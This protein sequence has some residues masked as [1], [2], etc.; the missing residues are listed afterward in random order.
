MKKVMFYCQHLAGMGHLVRSTEIIRSLLQEFQVYFINGGQDV[1]GFELPPNVEVITLPALRMEGPELKAVDATVSLE[2]VQESRKNL[3]LQMFEQIQPDCF[4]TESFPFSKHA[5]RFELIPLLKHIQASGRQTRVVCCL[6]DIIMTQV[7]TDSARAKKQE[8]TCNWVSQYYD[9]VLFHSDPQLQRLEECFS[10]VEDLDCEIYYTGFVA[11]SPPTH[12]A[13]DTADLAALNQSEPMILGSVGGGRHGYELLN[14]IAEASPILEKALPHKIYLFTGPFMAEA[15]V[16]K[17]QAA[18]DQ[19]KN[20]TIRR[21]TPHLIDYMNKADLSISMAG[22]NTTMN[23]LRTGVRSLVFPSPSEDQSG[24]QSLRSQKLEKL[25]VLQMLQ[26]DDL[27]GDRLAQKMITYLNQKPVSHR[28]TH[29]F[30]LQ[31]APKSASRLKEL[32]NEDSWFSDF[33]AIPD[34]QAPAWEL[35]QRSSSFS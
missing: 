35:L 16:L 5:L 9:L 26:S 1:P 11:Q 27:T 33:Q 30:D 4:I 8:R 21:F 34:S 12:I 13:P 29:Q 3:L 6:R 28:F 2:Q 31:G 19:Q 20:L 18:A 32:L 10:R 17:L 7:M 25:G 14:A 15:E 23:I 22:Y 24:E